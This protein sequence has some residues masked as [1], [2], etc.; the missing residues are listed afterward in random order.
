VRE[1]LEDVLLVAQIH[2]GQVKPHRMRVGV[3][4]VFEATARQLEHAARDRGVTIAYE[5]KD[6][7]VVDADGVLFRRALEIAIASVFAQVADGAAIVVRA[8]R[9]ARVVIELLSNVPA[10]TAE[11][12]SAQLFDDAGMPTAALTTSGGAAIRY[13]LLRALVE[14]HGG[15]LVSGPTL[16]LEFPA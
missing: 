16:R 12:V 5:A 2:A 14:A 10:F 11:L 6:A 15:A 7:V 4:A 9:G 13:S 1:T 3:R 8:Q